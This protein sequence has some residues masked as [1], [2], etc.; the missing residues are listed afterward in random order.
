MKS[1]AFDKSWMVLMEALIRASLD[2]NVAL[3]SDM[4][5]FELPSGM[6]TL[7][8]IGSIHLLASQS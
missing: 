8:F 4:N 3:K 1:D 7:I 6:D 5:G 2:I